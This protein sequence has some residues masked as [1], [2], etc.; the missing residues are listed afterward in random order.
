ME[1][2]PGR[3]AGS[4]SGGAWRRRTNCRATLERASH[5]SGSFKKMHFSLKTA[6]KERERER[7]REMSNA[8]S[9]RLL[10]S[11][12]SA[13]SHQTMFSL[14][15]RRSTPSSLSSPLPSSANFGRSG[16]LITPPS[17]HTAYVESGWPHERRAVEKWC[18]IQQRGLHR[19]EREPR[20]RG[21]WQRRRRR[22]WKTITVQVRREARQA[23]AAAA[24]TNLEWT[25]RR[26]VK[27]PRCGQSGHLLS[28]LFP[29]SL[30]LP[31]SLLP[32]FFSPFLFPVL[33]LRAAWR[34]IPCRP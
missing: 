14:G 26:K 12:H 22:A 7:E 24:P 4:A 5:W 9:V 25:R 20:V 31:P 34:S 27:S 29:R 16:T 19:G 32:S 8:K 21:A 17:T 23:R 6:T 15:L 1:R 18:R 3:E 28:T 13:S 11:S 10:H 30:P 33:F 2:G